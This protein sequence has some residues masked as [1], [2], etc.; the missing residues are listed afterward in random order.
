MKLLAKIVLACCAVVPV[1]KLSAAAYTFDTDSQGWKQ[2]TIG[3]HGQYYEHMAE[4]FAA[5]W[6]RDYGVGSVKG[7]LFQ[8]SNGTVFEARP[9]WLGTKGVTPESSL[10]D[11]TG[12]SLQ[13]SIR[14]TAN[15]VGRN[16]N[17][18]VYARWRIAKESE[19]SATM[20]VSKAAFSIN[21]NGDEWGDGSDNYWLVKS[22]SLEESNFF[23]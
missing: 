23:R 9:Y 4:V 15:W 16:P 20:Y 10:G 17:D 18:I 6:T 3:Y 21:L 12:K 11:L 1:I 2:S 7:S 14:S 5:N 13:V 22:I 8:S 19:T